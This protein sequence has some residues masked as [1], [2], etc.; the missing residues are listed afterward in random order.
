MSKVLYIKANSKP[1]GVSN[2][3]KISDFFLNEYKNKHPN[4]EITTLDLYKE[5]V[6]FLSMEEIVAIFSPKNDVSQ[7]NFILRYAYQFAGMDKFIIAAPMWNLGVP[8]I[9]KAYIDY[10]SISGITFN[11]T[12]NGPVGLLNN[13]KSVYIMTSGGNYSIPPYSEFDLCSKY[14]KTIFAFFGI[15]DFTTITAE[16][17]N[18]VGTDIEAEL[19]KAKCKC[20]EMVKYF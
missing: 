12:E 5:G 13:K 10:V 2:T 7:N 20:S 3:F 9:L 14:L 4:D 15:T 8:A 6:N 19:E 17:L 11:Y 18:V 1:E 16:N